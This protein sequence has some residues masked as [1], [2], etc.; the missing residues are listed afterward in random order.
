MKSVGSKAKGLAGTA[1]KLAMGKIGGLLKGQL[2]EAKG[3]FLGKSETEAPSKE[4]QSG[5]TVNV[6]G[7]GGNMA[8]TIADLFQENKRLKAQIAELEKKEA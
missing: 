7:G 5:V 2:S 8:E 1:G 3:Q 4:P 6:G